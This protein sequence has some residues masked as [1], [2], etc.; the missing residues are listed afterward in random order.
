M[1]D[2][3]KFLWPFHKIRTLPVTEVGGAPR[4]LFR[5]DPLEAADT[6]AIVEEL[7]E[8]APAL[9]VV[10]VLT[11][12]IDNP[13]TVVLVGITL[14]AA[15]DAKLKFGGWAEIFVKLGRVALGFDKV[16]IIGVPE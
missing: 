8:K 1:G 4:R 15:V 12:P 5:V 6:T 11:A 3:F 2:C 16:E 10:P 9:G 13:G 7:N 14:F